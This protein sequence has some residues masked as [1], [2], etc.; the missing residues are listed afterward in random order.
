MT[1]RV[2]HL[3]TAEA[4]ELLGVTRQTVARWCDGGQ[5]KADRTAGG[6]QRRGEWRIKPSAV[7]D[8]KRQA[9]NRREP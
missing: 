6:Q 2:K 5:L 4:A 1:P 9:N 7:E 3:T 8:L